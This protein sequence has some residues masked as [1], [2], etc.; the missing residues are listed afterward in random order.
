MLK[1]GEGI[2]ADAEVYDDECGFV[3]YIVNPLR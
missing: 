2:L 3:F 1:T